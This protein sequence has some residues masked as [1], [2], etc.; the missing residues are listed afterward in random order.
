MTIMREGGKVTI[1]REEVMVTIVRGGGEGDY[2]KGRKR[3]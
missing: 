3:G 1:T 2:H